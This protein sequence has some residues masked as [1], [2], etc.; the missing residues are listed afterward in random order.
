LAVFNL[1]FLNK[2][3]KTCLSNNLKTMMIR[4]QKNTSKLFRIVSNLLL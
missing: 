2:T 3:N 4:S 1:K